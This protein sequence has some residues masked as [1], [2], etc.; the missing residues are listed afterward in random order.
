MTYLL[1]QMITKSFSGKNWSITI[2]TWYMY[3]AYLMQYY[4]E[5]IKL[6]FTV[7]YP[8]KCQALRNANVATVNVSFLPRHIYITV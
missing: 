3:I 8:T 5:H 4:A 2:Q 7:S 6:F 1:D